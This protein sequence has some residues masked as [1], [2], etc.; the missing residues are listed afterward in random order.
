VFGSFELPYCGASQAQPIVSSIL[1]I[2]YTLLGGYICVNMSLA[3][4]AIGISE[5]LLQ[6]RSLDV[7]GG[8]DEVLSVDLRGA[9]FMAIATTVVLV[10]VFTYSLLLYLLYET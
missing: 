3:V 9:Y 10:C 1:F 5:R 8:S 6:L 2:T 7:F 4:V